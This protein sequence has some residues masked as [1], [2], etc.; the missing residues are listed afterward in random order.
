MANQSERTL[1]HAR[2]LGLLFFSLRL[3][4]EVWTG[5]VNNGEDR[6]NR[7]ETKDSLL[8]KNGEDKEYSFCYKTNP[9]VA[10]KC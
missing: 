7:T 8:I 5:K 10:W 3:R 2:M 6:S 9:T 1:R 4:F